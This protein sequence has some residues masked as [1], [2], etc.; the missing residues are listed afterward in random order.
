V[1]SKRVI[2][3]E[4]GRQ[5]FIVHHDPVLRENLV[6]RLRHLE[7]EAY[8]IEKPGDVELKGRRD[9]V[10]FLNPADLKSGEVERLIDRM[11]SGS[12]PLQVVSLGK[13]KRSSRV[14]AVIEAEPD[15]LLDGIVAYLEEIHARGHRHHVRFGS[16]N[17]SIAMFNFVQDE[18]R[19]AG[20]IHD[21]SSAAISCTFRPEPENIDDVPISRMDISLPSDKL[22]LS[23]RF[24]ID[25]EV[26]GHP[27]HVFIFDDNLP[28]E[29]KQHIYNFIYTSLETKLSLH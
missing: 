7:F 17:A 12:E 16:Q 9:S 6:F 1:I 21:I 24:T 10:L 4:R 20:V 25:R 29:H 14:D 15:E 2:M 26:A 19:F 27:V 13:V 11:N 28:V 18:R 3:D 8:G 23:G 5:I 22:P